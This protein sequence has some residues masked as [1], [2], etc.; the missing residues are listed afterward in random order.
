[1]FLTG[2]NLLE[3]LNTL[4]DVDEESL[5]VQC[6]VYYEEEHE[7]NEQLSEDVAD[8]LDITSHADVFHALF[9]KVVNTPQASALLGILR[10]LLLIDPEQEYG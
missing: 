5:Q 7:D 8:G 10:G 9:N 3:V 1:M 2:L 4:R 6:D